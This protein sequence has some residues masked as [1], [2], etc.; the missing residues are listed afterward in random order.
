M[1]IFHFNIP[2]FI[3]TFGYIGLC[4][5]IFAESGL[6]FGFFFPGDSL[7]FSAGLIASQGFFD[8]RVLI[9]LVS[10]AAILGD[11]VGYWFG[12]KVG[13][14]IFTKE[15]SLFFHKRHIE[16]TRLFYLKYGPRAIVLARFV[17]VVRTFTPIFAGVGNMPY[18]IFIRYNIIGGVLWGAG[19]TTLGYV[20]GAFVPG[21][22]AYITPIALGIIT[23][24]FFPV[25]YELYKSRI[26][27]ERQIP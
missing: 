13:P 21:I 23:L 2:L 18:G 19:L 20:L 4:A 1:D 8:V 5:I 7:L 15:D 25:A 3:T 17:P 16:R 26:I 22:D 24:S 11:N 27:K 12:V 6:F 9:I 10:V 14:K